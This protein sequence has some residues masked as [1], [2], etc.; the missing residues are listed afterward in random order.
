MDAS[1]VKVFAIVQS[2][3]GCC[4]DLDLTCAS[5]KLL[6]WFCFFFYL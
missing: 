1:L 5:A 3:Y 2:R 6:V 4:P